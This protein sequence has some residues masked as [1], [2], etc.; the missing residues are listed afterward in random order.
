[1][2]CGWKGEAVRVWA[3]M[4]MVAGKQ[5]K[6]QCRTGNSDLNLISSLLDD[7]EACL[8]DCLSTLI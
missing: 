7:L 1:M 2:F 6:T 8:L 5:I 4:V 3:T